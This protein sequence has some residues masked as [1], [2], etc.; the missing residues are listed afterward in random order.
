MS[1]MVDWGVYGVTSADAKSITSSG[2]TQNTTLPV[3]GDGT[4]ARFCRL[5]STGSVWVKLGVSGVTVAA[6]G[7][8][9]LLVNTNDVVLKTRGFSH[10]AVIQQSAGAILNIAPIE[11]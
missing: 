3:Q 1:E 5:V 2:S 10:I 6:S 4:T 11:V 8:G 7:A 9:A